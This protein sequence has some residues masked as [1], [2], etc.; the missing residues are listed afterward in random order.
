MGRGPA[1]RPKRIRTD[2]MPRATKFSPAPRKLR[3]RKAQ[4]ERAVKEGNEE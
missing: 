1:F 2:E 3:T 4:Q